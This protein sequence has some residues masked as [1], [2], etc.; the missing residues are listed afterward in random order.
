MAA[1]KTLS[2]AIAPLMTLNYLTGL[3]LSKYSR[4]RLRT[5]L[6][7]TYLLLLVGIYCKSIHAV[8][9]YFK[10]IKYEVF[11]SALYKMIT[12]LNAFVVAYEIVFGCFYTKVSVSERIESSPINCFFL[13]IYS[14]RQ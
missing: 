13:H 3:R 4:G 9:E 12:Y 7:L 5:A 8:Y 11:V 6:N 1:P 14:S 2:D 10:I